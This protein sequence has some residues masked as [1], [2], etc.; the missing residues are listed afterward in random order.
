[1]RTDASAGDKPV[2]LIVVTNADLAGAPSHVR[3]LVSELR[4]RFHLI[5]AFGE[6]GPIKRLLAG[7]GIDT[8][9]LP[10]L[11]SR[12]SP[13][14]DLRTIF[15]L[16]R[17]IRATRASL[18]HAHST[19]AG[20]VARIAGLMTAV[21]VVFT[22][23][24]WGFGMGRPKRQSR[25]V[26][27]TERWLAPLG[28]RYIAVS[29]A[30]AEV[31]RSELGLEAPRMVVVHNG[32]R[33]QE[34]RADP[35]M[36]DG[37][38]MVARVDWSKDHETALRAFAG[39]CTRATFTC[40]G[41][42]TREQEFRRD[43][44]TWAGP[45]IDRVRFVGETTD[46]PSHLAGAGVFVLVSRYEG[47]PLSIIEAMRA[48]LPVVASDAGGVCELVEHGVN[49]MLVP[50]G[51]VDGLRD[52]L[53]RLLDDPELRAR[54]GRAS[55]Q[56]YEA[57]FQLEPMCAKVAGLYLDALVEQP[58][59]VLVRRLSEIRQAFGAGRPAT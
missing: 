59:G 24:G 4:D 21:P 29:A 23:H 49:G 30:D 25:I 3:D 26:R 43:G 47:L 2:V 31:A 39:L 44:Q 42:G 18:V 34:S 9:L 22:V 11:A 40:I 48:G 16:V 51:Y 35:A 27:I 14:A 12:I 46:V 56:R 50:I 6:D 1:M 28:S 52:A 10:R 8:R 13:I 57:L 58:R 33:D 38:V 7:Q 36:S 17:L 53:Q 41:A 54:L 32:V 45:A 20:M 55:R 5:V 15:A 19:K 37:I